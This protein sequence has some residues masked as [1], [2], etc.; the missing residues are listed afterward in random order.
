LAEV[1]RA[2]VS[3]QRKSFFDKIKEYFQAG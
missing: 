1:E 2:H 3:P